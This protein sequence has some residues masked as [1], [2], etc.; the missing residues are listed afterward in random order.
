MHNEDRSND[1]SFKVD[2]AVY[3]CGACGFC[4]GSRRKENL[5]RRPAPCSGSR[6]LARPSLPCSGA[7]VLSGPKSSASSS[8]TSS[9][10]SSSSSSKPSACDSM[11][12]SLRNLSSDSA[13]PAVDSVSCELA[14]FG[15][16][17]HRHIISKRML[18]RFKPSTTNKTISRTWKEK[19]GNPVPCHWFPQ[20][21]SR[22]GKL[23]QMTWWWACFFDKDTTVGQS[24]F[25]AKVS[26]F[27]PTHWNF[28]RSGARHGA[29]QF[30]GRTTF[31][32]FSS[33]WQL[34]CVED[35]PLIQRSSS[36]T[37]FF[38]V[39][40]YF[41][42]VCWIKGF[43]PSRFNRTEAQT[44]KKQQQKCTRS[45]RASLHTVKKL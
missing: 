18:S 16:P 43:I 36:T 13:L 37:P 5:G 22:K 15:R 25:N 2:W 6:F 4:L 40:G 7:L 8:A 1:D 41:R 10:A 17:V 39:A 11:A 32:N 27:E 26:R 3:F 31:G 30:D 45:N 14:V 33:N 38:L 29:D 44:K 34:T 42:C 21:S 20:R 28:W 35:H 12:V 9:W 24:G 19:K 23:G